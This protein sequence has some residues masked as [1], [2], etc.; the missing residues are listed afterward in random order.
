LAQSLDLTNLSGWSANLLDH[1]NDFQL[2]A[3]C[4]SSQ[5]IFGIAFQGN[6]AILYRCF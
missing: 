4:N 2:G 3:A 5:G 6:N 1:N